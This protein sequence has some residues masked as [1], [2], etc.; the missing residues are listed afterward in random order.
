[1]SKYVWEMY[2]KPEKGKSQ[3]LIGIGDALGDAMSEL[4]LQVEEN[5]DQTMRRDLVEEMDAWRLVV[6][7]EAIAKGEVRPRF[8]FRRDTE[9]INAEMRELVDALD[10]QI[11][12]NPSSPRCLQV[13]ARTLRLSAENFTTMLYTTEPGSP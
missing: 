6:C 4:F 2:R 3:S 8:S 11:C 13:A 7:E 9:I 1:M 12:E 5:G 10:S